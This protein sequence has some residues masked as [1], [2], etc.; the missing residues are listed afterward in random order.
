MVNM[1]SGA[2]IASNTINDNQGSGVYVSYDSLVSLGTLTGTTFHDL[3]NTT[4]VNNDYSGLGCEM[5]ATVSGRIGSLNGDSGQINNNNIGIRTSALADDY[6]IDILTAGSGTKNG[7]I[8]LGNATANNTA[9]IARMVVR[10]YN[11]AEEPVYLFGSAS[12]A[13]DNF[14]A[15]GGGSTLGNAATQLDLFTAALFLNCQ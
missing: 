13:T 3:P 2:N 11:N 5:G 12:T 4:T 1:A 14:V 6:G 15:F 8:L 10:H 7:L 9:K